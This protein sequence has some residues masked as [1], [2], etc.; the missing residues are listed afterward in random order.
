VTRE[1]RPLSL[2]RRVRKAPREIGAR[3]VTR[4]TPAARESADSRATR[5]STEYK[6]IPVQD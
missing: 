2:D 5:E 1:Q 4:E 6:E 3:K